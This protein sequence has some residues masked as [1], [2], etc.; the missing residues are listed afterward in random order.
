MK[1]T[2]KYFTPQLP[3]SRGK[4]FDYEYI[5]NTKELIKQNVKNL[6]LTSPGERVMNPDFGVGIRKYL[7]ENM[8]LV[9]PQLT[10]RIRN[11]FKEYMPF[12]KLV[13][14]ETNQTGENSISISVVYDIPGLGQQDNLII[15]GRSGVSSG[16]PK[17]VI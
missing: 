9:K 5:D 10:E 3:L 6:L 2:R 8:D 14:T 12:V 13:S 7:F 16:G 17:F 4:S 15:D 11:Q 1:I